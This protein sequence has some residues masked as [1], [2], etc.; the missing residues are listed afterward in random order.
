MNI[1]TAGRV[2]APHALRPG[3]V[4]AAAE[5]SRQDTTTITSP[6][7]GARPLV[8]SVATGSS[9]TTSA[10]SFR[11]SLAPSRGIL[12]WSPEQAITATVASR[13]APEGKNT[14]L[15]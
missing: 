9:L 10:I 11:G 13:N 3:D 4:S 6:L 5:G 14:W 15:L 1:S 12:L 2:A 8:S 7:F